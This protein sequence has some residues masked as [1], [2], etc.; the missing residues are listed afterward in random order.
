MS[1]FLGSIHHWLYGK[2]EFQNGLVERLSDMISKNGYD[3][4]IL[5][6]MEQKYGAVEKGSL[7][8]MIDNSNIHG[9]LQDKIAAAENRLAFLVISTMDAHSECMPD[10]ANAAYEY[11]R[12]R[13][14]SGKT[15]AEEVYRHLD[16]LLLNGMPCDRVNTVVSISQEA[17]V[18]K[19]TVDIH[20]PYWEAL[21]GDVSHYIRD[22]NT[23]SQRVAI[24]SGMTRADCWTKHYRGIAMP[25]YRYIAARHV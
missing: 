10:I 6:E 17:V 9:W 14:L 20:L 13:K 16:N 8:N 4:G 7:E 5:S 1:A 23:A 25:H 12:S 2:I 18:W 15:S 21:Q 22:T 19:Q 24:R 11:G 3:D